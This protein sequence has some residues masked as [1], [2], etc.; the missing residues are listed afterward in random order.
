MSGK[1]EKQEIKVLLVC[2][3]PTVVRTVK[4][5]LEFQGGLRI[6]TA[7][8]NDEALVKIEKTTP[9]VIVGDFTGL[10]MHARTKGS[11][12]V[13][14]LRS[15]GDVTPFIVLSYNDEK[16]L[17]ADVLELGAIG[18]VGKSGDPS[19]VYSNLKNCIVSITARPIDREK[20]K[21]PSK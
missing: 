1:D 8:S 21:F 6:E 17:I 2:Y 3:D 11:E 19:M 5:C 4:S 9:D 12:L 20:G 10:C 18:F 16:E 15:K 13:K 7:S 14:T